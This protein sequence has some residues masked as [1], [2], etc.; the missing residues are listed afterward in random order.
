MKICGKSDPGKERSQ[1]Q[2][3]FDDAVF[4]NGV[5]CAVVCDGMGGAAA[6]DRASRIAID[7]IMNTL[8]ERCTG[9]IGDP[10]I[11]KAM[12]TAVYKANSE[13][14]AT[15]QGDPQLLGMGTTAVIAVVNKRVLHIS[16]IGDSRIYSFLNGSLTR[17]TRDHSLVNDMLETGE[18]T[19]DEAAIHPD[20]N[21]ITRAIGVSRQV[22]EDYRCLVMHPGEVL[23]LCTDGL[24]NFVDDTVIEYIM[25]KYRFE[26]LPAKLVDAANAGG[27]GDN[28]TAVV[29][30]T[31]D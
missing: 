23:L 26:N 1:N 4:S 5:G 18:I 7:S 9:P 25:G 11:R 2:D 14:F 12:Q 22:E 15:A 31:E 20:R 19:S 10:E 29:V 17:L 8:K 3:L 21:V 24:C 6:G 16:H 30:K 28:I 13:V 27:G